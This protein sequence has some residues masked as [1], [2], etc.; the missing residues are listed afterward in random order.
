MNI[1]EGYRAEF[2]R[3]EKKHKIKCHRYFNHLN[4]S[5][6]AC[7][8]L[9]LPL[10]LSE[11]YDRQFCELLGVNPGRITDKKFEKIICQEEG[12]NFDFY[13]KHD[14]GVQIYLE[15]KYT[16]QEF[17]KAVCNKARR[18]KLKKIYKPKLTGKISCE[19]LEKEKF[20][21]HYQLLRNLVYFKPEK[22]DLV[23]FVY[24]KS[25]EKLKDTSCD[26]DKIA[27][28]KNIR[29]AIK[30]RHLE[31]IVGYAIALFSGNN[32]ALACHY[33]RYQEKYFGYA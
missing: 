5:Q 26:L 11:R 10:V 21:S 25:N 24:P 33:R 19:Y 30:V 31:D 32:E 13:M 2:I 1:L 14:S 29:K 7:F 3:Y 16:E 23:I 20:F 6:A 22:G 4:S 12:T 8:N 18:E 28:E 27:P 15:F 17:G 9:F